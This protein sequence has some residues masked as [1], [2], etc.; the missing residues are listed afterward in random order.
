MKLQTVGLI[1]HRATGL[2]GPREQGAALDT[3]Q[4]QPVVEG[5]LTLTTG[6]FCTLVVRAVTIREF[7]QTKYDKEIN[8]V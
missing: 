8:E 6:Y 3:Q 1:E 5:G 7:E 4:Q 2:G